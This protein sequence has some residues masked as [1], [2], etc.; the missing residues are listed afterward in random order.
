MMNDDPMS[1]VW[2]KPWQLLRRATRATPPPTE[3]PPV[4]SFTPHHRRSF[5]TPSFPIPL[6]LFHTSSSF[7]RHL[8]SYDILVF[9]DIDAYFYNHDMTVEEIVDRFIDPQPPPP[10]SPPPSP[11]PADSAGEEKEA[12]LNEGPSIIVGMD[13]E[14]ATARLLTH[15]LPARTHQGLSL[16]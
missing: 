4:P 2:A 8:P 5:N 6:P 16:R 10:P 12:E 15:L 11:P 3:E 7:I 1:V 9:F 14:S 13:C